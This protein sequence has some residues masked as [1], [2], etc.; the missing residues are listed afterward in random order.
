M[1]RTMG[2]RQ[3]LKTGAAFGAAS[4]AM[5]SILRAQGD[6][7]VIAHLTP[8]T[9]FLGPMGEYAVMAADLAVEEINAAGGING[10]ELQIVKE[11]SVNPQTATTK[12]E[13]LVERPEIAMIVG[14]ISSAS[15]LSIAQ[16]TARAN[17]LF[18]NTGANSD[19]LRGK[20]CKRTMFHTEAQNAMYVNAEG[21]FFLQN[22]MVKG[23]KWFIVSAD[24]AFGHDLRNGAL[25]FLERN[26]GEVVGDELIPTDATDFSSYLLSIRSQAPDL[27]VV[28]LAGTQT[29]SFFKQFGEFGLELPIGGFDYNSSIAW[30][31]GVRDFKG[32]WPC[33]WTHQVQTDGSQ[34]FAKAFQAKYGKPAENQAYSDY[35]AIRIAAEAIKATGGTDTDALIAYLEDPATEFDILKERKGRFDPASHQLLQE[36]Y[37]VTAVDPSEAPNEW[38]IFTTSGALPGADAPLEEL[39]KG[40]VG[41]T[42]SF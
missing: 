22:D 24:Y 26:G 4:L 37:A 42:C 14:E 38:D 28:N 7:L 12:A 9:G 30:A 40:A 2:R 33:I 10:R 8:R 39:I 16:V 1:F 25:A 35:I 17:K 34:A 41:G 31:T 18:I 11:D 27:V 6:P 5:P 21:A 36:V 15:A 32:T 23:K 29:A 13:R 3:L 20:D 19:T